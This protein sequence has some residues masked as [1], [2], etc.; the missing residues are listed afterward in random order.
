MGMDR[1]HYFRDHLGCSP[2]IDFAHCWYLRL[3]KI[4]TNCLAANIAGPIYL[5]AVADSVVRKTSFK[6]LIGLYYLA[7]AALFSIG[8]AP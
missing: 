4:V 3:H 2:D 8:S 6:A 5:P 1:C 7:A